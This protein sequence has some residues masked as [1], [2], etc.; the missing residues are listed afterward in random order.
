VL[1]TT[2]IVVSRVIYVLI[3]GTAMLYLSRTIMV[4]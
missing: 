4:I 1:V 2:K 3:S